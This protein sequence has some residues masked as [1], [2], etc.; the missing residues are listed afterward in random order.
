MHKQ[1]LAQGADPSC[2][3]SP[4]RAFSSLDEGVLLPLSGPVNCDFFAKWPSFHRPGEEYPLPHRTT[5][6]LVSGRCGF[7]FPQ[8]EEYSATQVCHILIKCSN[9]W[10]LYKGGSGTTIFPVFQLKW[11]WLPCAMR[12]S[13]LQV[14]VR[15]ARSTCSGFC[16]PGRTT[17]REMPCL[18]IT[19]RVA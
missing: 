3:A 7:C 17:G 19:R 9:P 5:F 12:E 10:A 13:L 15:C 6:S 8:A 14:C 16:L 18:K 11:L 2:L 1:L 4:Q